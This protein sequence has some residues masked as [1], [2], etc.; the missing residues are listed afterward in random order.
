VIKTSNL[1]GLNLIVI[2][3][4]LESPQNSATIIE[5]ARKIADKI[6]LFQVVDAASV[7]GKEHLLSSFWHASR[8]FDTGR[9][10][11]SHF[12]LE[13]LLYAA[14]VRQIHQAI[15]SLGIQESTQ[16]I[17]LIAGSNDLSK[18][19]KI[20]GGYLKDIRAKHDDTVLEMSPEKKKYLAKTVGESS[21]RIDEAFF[22]RKVAETPLLTV[23]KNFDAAKNS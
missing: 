4:K 16:A 15:S 1:A 11:S 2:G 23:K 9:N 17:A 19:Q 7:G 22:L 3:A 5:K 21:I 18:L 14:G 6:P 12:S 8:H 20:V 13:I 10:I